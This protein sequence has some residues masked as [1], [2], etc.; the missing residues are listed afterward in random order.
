MRLPPSSS[1]CSCPKRSRLSIAVTLLHAA[2]SS[3]SWVLPSEDSG[4]SERTCGA[5]G[6]GQLGTLQAYVLQRSTSK[7]AAASSAAHVHG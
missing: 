2:Y 4:A 3:V 7:Q 1:T 5:A 6:E